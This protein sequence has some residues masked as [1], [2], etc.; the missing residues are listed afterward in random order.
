VNNQ[1]MMPGFECG[2]FG[3]VHTPKHVLAK[4]PHLMNYLDCASISMLVP[5][6]ARYSLLC[7]DEL[8]GLLGN[9]RW[10]NCVEVAIA[11]DLNAKRVNSEQLALNYTEND[12][13]GWYESITGFDPRNPATD[14]GTDPVDALIWASNQGLI[15]A[16]GQIDLTNDADIA[17]AI[18]AFGG[19]QIALDMQENWENTDVWSLSDSPLVGGH[20]VNLLDFC[21]NGDCTIATWGNKIRTLTRSGRIGRGR[22]AYATLA[23]PWAVDGHPC[24]FGLNVDQ[25][26]KELEKL[27]HVA[28]Q[29][30]ANNQPECSETLDDRA[31]HDACLPPE[32]TGLD[33]FDSSRVAD[34]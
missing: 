27:G 24:I 5:D 16:W 17:M 22:A 4:V 29:C 32:V 13:V 2:R 10:G 26:R 21:P 25:L 14:R 15:D 7:P 8:W 28:T 9:D 12:V 19:V 20:M 18:A 11:N 33:V 6:A 34:K 1:T 30:K 23:R 31:S 3:V